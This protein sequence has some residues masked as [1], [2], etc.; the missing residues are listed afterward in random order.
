MIVGFVNPI[1]IFQMVW[2][3][4]MKKLLKRCLKK[5]LLN[6]TEYVLDAIEFCKIAMT[7]KKL[8]GF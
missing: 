3:Y 8:S 4:I 6:R 5:M 1:R 7:L 2:K